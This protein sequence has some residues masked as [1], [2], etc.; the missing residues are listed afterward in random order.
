[1]NKFMLQLLL[2]LRVLNGGV[3][4]ITHSV[5]NQKHNIKTT[6]KASA[7]KKPDT[8]ETAQYIADMVLELRNMA[9]ASD[10]KSLQGL[11]EVSF[12]EAFSAANKV[13]IPPEELEKLRMLK[14]ASRT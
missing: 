4:M 10:L 14:A 12:Y 7:N 1:M 5:Y 9:K 8:R 11:L 2:N 6:L 3:T 13:D